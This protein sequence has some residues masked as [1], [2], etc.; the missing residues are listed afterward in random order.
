M[1]GTSATSVLA[2]VPG[3]RA[4]T[5]QKAEQATPLAAVVAVG[6]VHGHKI[7]LA[8]AAVP[9]AP[10]APGSRLGMGRGGYGCRS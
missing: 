7:T 2:A 3:G 9:V 1:R 10:A 5:V 6:S 4:A 8:G